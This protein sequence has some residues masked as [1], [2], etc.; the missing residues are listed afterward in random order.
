MLRVIFGVLFLVFAVALA[1][2]DGVL[3]MQTSVLEFRSLGALWYQL[4][5]GSLEFSQAII[6]RYLWPP[7]WEP[8]VT[9]I[10]LLPAWVLPSVF[11]FLLFVSAS[12]AK[13]DTVVFGKMVK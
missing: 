9:S 13:S 3:W 4:D 10:L 11:S 8:G 12:R 5:S 2:A 1:G 7:L 6:Q